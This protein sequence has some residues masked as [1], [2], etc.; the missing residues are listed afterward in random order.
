MHPVNMLSSQL[1]VCVLGTCGNRLILPLFL[2][3][4]AEHEAESTAE[5][6]QHSYF[7]SVHCVDG[8]NALFFF[9][10]FVSE[11]ETKRQSVFKV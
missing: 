2:H 5:E 11:K 3:I 10:F 4:A 1:K 9:F 7:L 8:E 6:T